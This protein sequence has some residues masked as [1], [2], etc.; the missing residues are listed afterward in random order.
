MRKALKMIA[1]VTVLLTT[2]LA[3]TIAAGAGMGGFSVTPNLPASQIPGASEAHFDLMVTPGGRYE[4]TVTVANHRDGEPISVSMRMFNAGTNRNGVM[5]YFEEAPSDENIPFRIDEIAS[6]PPGAD[7]IELPPNGYAE[8]TITLDVPPVSFDGIVLGSVNTLLGITDEERAEAG[9]F[10]P[11]FANNMPIRLRM[12]NNPV[13]PDFDLGDV[14]ADLTGYVGAFVVEIHHLA[15]R[16]SNGA[17]A[18][19]WIYPDGSDTAIFSSGDFGVDFAPNAIFPMTMMDGEGFGIHPGDYLARAR[20]E[21]SG[22]VWEFERRF[23][24]A[25]AAAAAINQ[26]AIGGQQAAHPAA[27]NGGNPLLI[28]LIVIGILLLLMMMALLL[29]KFKKSKQTEQ[30]DSNKITL[31]PQGISTSQEDPAPAAAPAP[32]K[33]TAADQLK[34]MNKEELTALLAYMEKKKSQENKGE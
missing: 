6:L 31:T 27:A 29:L 21:Y 9:M 16:L 2:M 10:V 19:A 23:T 24:V 12:N 26:A 1:I 25:P 18:N 30:P 20:V 13:E 34:G 28:I 5:T 33:G 7:N 22:R 4:F 17:V 11:R 8:V 3:L 32:A 15:A 14:R